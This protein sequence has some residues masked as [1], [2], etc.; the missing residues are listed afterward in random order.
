MLKYL[1]SI[2]P[3]ILFLLLNFFSLSFADSSYYVFVVDENLKPLEG[4][5]ILPTHRE[6]IFIS[7]SEPLKKWI[8]HPKST[9][10]VVQDGVYYPVKDSVVLDKKKGIVLLIVDLSD[11]KNV[12]FHLEGIDKDL[13][14]RIL[15]DSKKD[16]VA[17]IDKILPSPLKPSPEVEATKTPQIELLSLAESYERA[18]QLERAL[19]FYEELTRLYPEKLEFLDK[20]ATLNYRLGNFA[21]AKQYLLKM[22]M[23]EKVLI[24]LT[25]IYVIEKNFEGALRLLEKS[26]TVNRSYMHYLK[27][28][29]YYL[30]NRRDEAY[31]ELSTLMTLDKDLSQNLRDLLR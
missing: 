5:K 23:D 8:V 22:P 19:Y 24:K 15:L 7:K 30:L 18:G 25:G 21:K 28:I 9:M 1:M 3:L 2:I 14:V 16:I 20:V 29:L 31:K 13:N 12:P 10:I 4:Y 6:N 27:G 17:K 26:S 11:R